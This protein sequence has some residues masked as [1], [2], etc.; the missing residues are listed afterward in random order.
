MQLFRSKYYYRVS[1]QGEFCE[2]DFTTRQKKS[3]PCLNFGVLNQKGF[4]FVLYPLVLLHQTSFKG[5]EHIELKNNTAAFC[6]GVFGLCLCFVVHV[7]LFNKQR[8]QSTLFTAHHISDLNLFRHITA[9]S[10]RI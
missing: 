8:C 5:A 6:N 4:L 3:H 7:I 10:L 9:P 2:R 1:G